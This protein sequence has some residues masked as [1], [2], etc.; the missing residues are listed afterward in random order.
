M[1][2]VRDFRCYD[3]RLFK[4]RQGP[5]L[6]AQLRPGPPTSSKLG[7]DGQTWVNLRR[8]IQ[9]FVDQLD[10]ATG[11]TLDDVPSG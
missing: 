5:R 7:K 6:T 11:E 3:L 2:R 9:L 8:I 4:L 1:E 10:D